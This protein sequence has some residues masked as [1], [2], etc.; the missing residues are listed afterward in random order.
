MPS[1]RKYGV[2]AFLRNVLLL[3]FFLCPLVAQEPVPFSPRTERASAQVIDFKNVMLTGGVRANGAT[4]IAW[5]EYGT[6]NSFSIRTDPIPVGESFERV[7]IT[8]HITP[9][10][11]GVAHS[12]RVMASNSFGLVPIPARAFFTVTNSRPVLRVVRTNIVAFPN[13]LSAPL[14]IFVDDLETLSDNLRLTTTFA[15]TNGNTNLVDLAASVFAGAGTNRSLQVRSLLHEHGEVHLRLAVQDEHGGIA[16]TNLRFLVE[17]FSAANHSLGA[18]QAWADLDQDGWL[19][20]LGAG[21]WARNPNST[22]PMVILSGFYS[23][24][25]STVFDANQDGSID[26]IAT[27]FSTRLYSTRRRNSQIDLLATNLPVPSGFIFG[28]RTPIDYDLDGDTDIVAFGRTS[29]TSTRAQV[30]IL[31][32]DRDLSFTALPLARASDVSP[33]WTDYDLD[34]DPDLFLPS[35]LDTNNVYAGL[36]LND[37]SGRFTN[38]GV[39]LPNESLAGSDWGDFNGDGRPDLYL[40][41]IRGEFLIYL[42]NSARSLSLARTIPRIGSLARGVSLAD[43]NNDGHLDLCTMN[44]D[45]MFQV[46]SAPPDR[47]FSFLYLNHPEH[48]GILGDFENDGKLD[49]LG[50]RYFRNNAARSNSPPGAPSALES[51]VSGDTVLLKWNAAADLDQSAGLTYNVRVGMTPGGNEIVSALSDPATG[52][53]WVVQKGNAFLSLQRLIRSLRPGTYHWSVQAIDNSFAGGSFAPAQTFTIPP[54]LS[55]EI[56]GFSGNRLVLKVSASATLEK[57]TDLKTWV[58][59]LLER[60]GESV[61]LDLATEPAQ[62]IRARE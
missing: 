51:V 40:S 21:S 5:F 11:L 34:G 26:F 48:G 59:L 53:R 58:P 33:A 36:M 6:N 47:G 12:V 31:R 13:Q 8:N 30:L 38:S 24:T 10:T 1:T 3:A 46:I 56:A 19:D 39:V 61:T 27:D 4:T 45:L 52:R 14:N 37:G 2:R 28:V 57:S 54:A 20:V 16:S 42:Q 55:L 15:S 22:S 7:D 60:T 23:G 17:D 9:I 49:L 43:L 50:L 41:T 62:F 35:S 18:A 25:V 29:A 32:N 44:S